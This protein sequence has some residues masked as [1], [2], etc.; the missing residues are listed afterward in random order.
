MESTRLAPS[1]ALLLASLS[2]AFAPPALALQTGLFGPQ[3]V[4]TT[5]ADCARSVY[6]VD[7][8]G[9]ADVLSA[10][11]LDDKIDH[12]QANRRNIDREESILSPAASQ[13]RPVG[14]SSE[15]QPDAAAEKQELRE[16]V[17]LALQFLDPVGGEIILRREYHKEPFDVI[18]EAVDISSADAAS[19]RYNRALPKLAWK[20]RELRRHETDGDS[21]SQAGEGNDRD[22]GD[23]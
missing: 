21:A 18:A 11:A 14:Q 19:M 2:T 5:A 10:S 7:L 22:R 4:I 23:S 16:W 9:D 1:R 12:L 8:D 17:K 20:I 6:A 15:D 13:D 3:Q